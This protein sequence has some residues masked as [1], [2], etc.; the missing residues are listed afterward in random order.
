MT[1]LAENRGKCKCRSFF[2]ATTH[3]ALKME[4]SRINIRQCKIT[5]F[6]FSKYIFLRHFDPRINQ[7]LTMLEALFYKELHKKSDNFF[8]VFQSIVQLPSFSAVTH[9]QGNCIFSECLCVSPHCAFCRSDFSSCTNLRFM[10]KS[11]FLFQAPNMLSYNAHCIVD[12]FSSLKS[13]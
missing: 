4:K 6:N 5:Y 8:P 2:R 12:H 11:F 1:L 10:P 7:N 13:C 9:T 3:S